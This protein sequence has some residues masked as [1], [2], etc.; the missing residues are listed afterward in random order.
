MNNTKR[1]KK[2]FKVP[3]LLINRVYIHLDSN[4]N[5]R[6]PDGL[7][8]LID[9]VAKYHPTAH[10]VTLSEEIAD[11]IIIYSKR[12][13]RFILKEIDDFIYH[14]G[15]RKANESMATY[16]SLTQIRSIHKFLL[17]AKT[18]IPAYTATIMYVL[19]KLLP[20]ECQAKYIC[21]DILEKIH[22][23]VH[24]YYLHNT[25]DELARFFEDSFLLVKKAMVENNNNLV[26]T[27]FPCIPREHPKESNILI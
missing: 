18:S 12:T 24:P 27:D 17:G 6:V 14:I 15:Q 25:D 2:I 20:P 13:Q 23:V 9:A 4:C 21:R 22:L 26:I 10:G 11:N 5:M 8:Y 3:D 19:F 16:T 7:S 1:I